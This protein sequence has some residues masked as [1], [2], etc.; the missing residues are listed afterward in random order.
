MKPA[1]NKYVLRKDGVLVPIRNKRELEAIIKNHA[2][3][4]NK[5][6]KIRSST[7]MH[8]VGGDGAIYPKPHGY[9]NP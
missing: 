9:Q 5:D 3:Y 1:D 4:T 2:P 6:F 7:C 8:V